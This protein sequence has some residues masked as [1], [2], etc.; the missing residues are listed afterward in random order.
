M[1]T[2][3]NYLVSVLVDVS[4]SMSN[5]NKDLV[6]GINNFLDQMRQYDNDN[7]SHT[8]IMFSRF[9]TQYTKAF[10]TAPLSTFPTIKPVDV[11]AG[12]GTHL[13][14]AVKHV[15]SDVQ[16]SLD[17]EPQVAK[18]IVFI[19]TD[20]CDYGSST[21]IAEAHSL[22]QQKITGN[23]WE[24]VLAGAN[25]DAIV[26]GAKYGLPQEACISWSAS[27]A[28]L[29]AALNSVCQSTIRVRQGAPRTFTP[30]E[31]FGASNGTS[32]PSSSAPGPAPGPGPAPSPTPTSASSKTKK[33]TK[34]STA[35]KIAVQ[36]KKTTQAKKTKA[37]RFSP[38][39]A[40]PAASSSSSAP[41]SPKIKSSKSPAGKKKVVHPT[42]SS[43]WRRPRCGLRLRSHDT[44]DLHLLRVRTPVS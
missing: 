2:Q 23:Q 43:P 7:G 26:T 16:K 13:H 35:K 33:S 19:L 17:N 28:A 30:G 18:V 11:Q 24:F 41:K 34:K 22:I 14:D 8:S 15:I 39:L 10:G 32:G 29:R 3:N 36:S 5:F 25:Q 9:N 40:S 44:S 42:V 27:G 12:G 20:G 38:R 31:R 1:A 21:S 37:S 6:D 4:G